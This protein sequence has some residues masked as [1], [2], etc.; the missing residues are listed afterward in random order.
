MQACTRSTTHFGMPRISNPFGK[1]FAMIPHLNIVHG[2]LRS[3][4]CPLWRIQASVD[5]PLSLLARLAEVNVA[6]PAAIVLCDDLGELP[7][8]LVAGAAH[9]LVHRV[10]VEAPDKGAL[11]GEPQVANK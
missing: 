7:G 1:T 8:L 3:A 10:R 4:P 9:A 11:H 2:H 6:P 5:L